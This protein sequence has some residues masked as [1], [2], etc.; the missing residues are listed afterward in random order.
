LTLEGT[1]GPVSVP[2]T[3][4]NLVGTGLAHLILAGSD[5]VEVSKIEVSDGLLTL[6][7]RYLR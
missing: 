7:G 5:Y 1:L 6:D 2:E 4:V 3:L